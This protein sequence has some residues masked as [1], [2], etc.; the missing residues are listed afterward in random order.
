MYHLIF[1]FILSYSDYSR[2]GQ[3]FRTH[4]FKNRLEFI[5]SYLL[6]I[7]AFYIAIKIEPMVHQ[8]YINVWL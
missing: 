2:S 6:R 3:Y 7:L 8:S 1:V 4:T 5:L